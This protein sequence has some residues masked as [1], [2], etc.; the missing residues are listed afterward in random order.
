MM[1]VVQ[2][3]RQGLTRELVREE[4]ERL[5]QHLCSGDSSGLKISSVYYQ[6][7]E[8]IHT[9]GRSGELVLLSGTGKLRETLMG[10]QF[11]ISPNAF[12]QVSVSYKCQTVFPQSALFN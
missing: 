6:L 7:C 1:V 11:C 9:G 8:S 3:H 10:V 4:C 12:F 2:V 5:Y